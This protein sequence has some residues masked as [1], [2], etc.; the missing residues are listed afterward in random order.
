MRES[1]KRVGRADHNPQGAQESG[2]QKP[3]LQDRSDDSAD[4]RTHGAHGK[5]RDAEQLDDD[6]PVEPDVTKSDSRGSTAWGSE[7]S[8]GSVSDRRSEK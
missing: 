3:S 5:G 7:A 4:Q 2:I 8:G 1:E 6:A